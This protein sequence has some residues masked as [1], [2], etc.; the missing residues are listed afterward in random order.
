M[1]TDKSFF[2][3]GAAASRSKNGFGAG[4]VLQPGGALYQ[5]DG[6]GYM[7][8]TDA[9]DPLTLLLLKNWDS[10]LQ[11][12]YIT[13]QFDYGPIEDSFKSSGLRNAK[14][15]VFIS[16]FSTEGVDR[17]DLVPADGG[18]QLVKTVAAHCA[19]T[20]VIVNSVSQ[21]NLEAWVD[22]P[23]VTTVVWS[24]IPGSEYGPAI[25]DILFGDYN[26]GGTL[27]FTLAKK[28]SDYGT[29]ISLTL[30]SNYEEGV[31]LDYRHFDKNNIVPRYHFGY[32]LS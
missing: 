31:F 1:T 5:G 7:E 32:G 15:L 30:T 24:G 29:D 9:I 23:N 20:I 3:Y 2:V 27:V 14:C 8:P 22:H 4:G 21:L 12:R 18:N 26:S 19:N 13:E 6:S 17:L 28:D 25:V 10:H 11:I 16:A